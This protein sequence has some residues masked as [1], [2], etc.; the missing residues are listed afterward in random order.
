M[1]KTIL[2][3]YDKLLIEDYKK[4]LKIIIGVVR[5]VDIDANMSVG[6]DESTKT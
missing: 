2:R 6:R 1:D 3:F 4:K 5:G